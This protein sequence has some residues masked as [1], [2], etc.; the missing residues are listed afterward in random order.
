MLRAYLVSAIALFG[1]TSLSAESAVAFNP[2]RP[3]NPFNRCIQELISAGIEAKEAGVACS[4]ALIP[5]ELSKCV[6]TINKHNPRSAD[7]TAFLNPEEML[8]TCYQVRRPVDLANCFVDINDSA[9][10]SREVAKLV[11]ESCRKSL[12]PGRHSQCVIAI[13]RNPPAGMNPE[14]MP[15][16]SKEAL[17]TC[18]A[19]EDFPPDLFPTTLGN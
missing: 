4:D 10:Q 6:I 18:L 2:L 12:L 16:W 3:R 14:E 8:K 15:N 19:A 7:N 17:K 13:N 5:R 1:L 9:A 11:L